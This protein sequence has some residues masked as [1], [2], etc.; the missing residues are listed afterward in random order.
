MVANMPKRKT[1]FEKLQEEADNLTFD[2][3]GKLGKLSLKPN[4]RGDPDHFDVKQLID[5]DQDDFH[6]GQSIL[7]TPKNTYG[8]G[9][10]TPPPHPNFVSQTP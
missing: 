10:L 4:R 1:D 5:N 3:V 7:K 8:G 6:R 9:A 2:D